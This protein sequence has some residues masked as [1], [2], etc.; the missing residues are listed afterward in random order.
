[1]LKTGHLVYFHW[2][3]IK[4]NEGDMV[5]MISIEYME[6]YWKFPVDGLQPEDISFHV[7]LILEE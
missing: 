2:K 4:K 1:M 5:N 3:F 6:P 7:L